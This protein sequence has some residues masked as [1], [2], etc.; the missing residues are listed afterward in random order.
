MPSTKTADPVEELAINI[1]KRDHPQR[2]WRMRAPDVFRFGSDMFATAEE[3]R[4]YCAFARGRLE[5]AARLAPPQ[6]QP[7]TPS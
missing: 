7:S 5:E 4:L 3:R 2:S 1:F 6:H